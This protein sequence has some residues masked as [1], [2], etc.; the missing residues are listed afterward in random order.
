MRCI[1]A[2]FELLEV[3]FSNARTDL[4]PAMTTLK[5]FVPA[6]AILDLAPHPGRS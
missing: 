2:G 4:I 5:Y 3:A 1:R 6:R